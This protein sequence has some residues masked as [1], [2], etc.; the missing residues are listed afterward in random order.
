MN[1]TSA[2]IG[3]IED[4]KALRDEL[5]RILSLSGYDVVVC[6]RFETAAEEMLAAAPDCV[7][8]DLKLPGADGHELCRALR[9][10]SAVPIVVITSSDVEFDE[11]M[12]LKLGADDYLTKPFSPALLQAHVEAALRRAGRHEAAELG[13]AGVRLDSARARVYFE[14]R[15][16]DLTRNELRLLAML[17]ASPDAVISREEMM[18]H[19]WETDVFIDDNTLTV[20]MNRLRRKLEELGVPPTF[21]ATRRGLGYQ[22]R[23]TLAGE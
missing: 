10:E 7:L 6:E 9:A 17:M 2:R 12:A 15:V 8:L 19:L 13:V 1:G 5:S 16:A 23:P 18:A 22:L 4:D 11:V 21:I 20:N 3:L 14:G